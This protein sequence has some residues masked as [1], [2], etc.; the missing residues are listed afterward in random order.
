MKVQWQC[1]KPTQRLTVSVTLCSGGSIPVAVQTTEA[2]YARQFGRHM[3][4]CITQYMCCMVL[5]TTAAAGCQAQ[6]MLLS[7][8]SVLHLC[9]SVLSDGGCCPAPYCH[10]WHATVSKAHL[11]LCNRLNHHQSPTHQSPTQQAAA[12]AAAVPSLRAERPAAVLQGQPH[13]RATCSIWLRT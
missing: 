13:I 8:Q 6:S 7:E 11:R 5:W 9:M 1:T 12:Y 2:R 4:M 3:L 10:C